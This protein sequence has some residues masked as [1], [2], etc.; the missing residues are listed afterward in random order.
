ME[1]EKDKIEKS[2]EDEGGHDT[3]S[4]GILQDQW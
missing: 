4:D 2:Y 1:K 3:W